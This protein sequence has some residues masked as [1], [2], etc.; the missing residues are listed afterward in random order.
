[1]EE[2]ITT[3]NKIKTKYRENPKKAFGH[4]EKEGVFKW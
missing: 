4:D 2:L 1:L 3:L